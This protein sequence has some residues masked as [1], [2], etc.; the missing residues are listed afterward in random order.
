MIGAVR[1]GGRH[2]SSCPTTTSSSPPGSAQSY[3][4]HDEYAQWAPGMKTHRRRAGP[5]AGGS[6]A[7][8]RWRRPRPTDDERRRWLTFALVGGG[9]TG[10][11]LAGQIRE[12]ATKTLRDEFRKIRPGGRPGAALRR[13]HSAAGRVRAE[14]RRQG[15]EALEELGVELHDGL[16]GHRR[17][18][19]WSRG[20]RQRRCPRPGTRPAPCC[21]P[22]ESRRRRSPACVAAATGA[23]Q[24]R[25]GRIVVQPDLTVAGSPGDLR[26]RRRDEPRRP[27]RARRGGDAVG[28][29]RRPSD[30]AP[31]CRQGSPEAV[32]LHRP[33]Q[34]GVHL[35]WPGD[36][37]GRSDQAVRPAGLAE[38]AV[39]PHR[40][41]DRLPQ[42]VHRGPDVVRGFQPRHA[43]RTRVH[44]GGD[45][46]R[47][48]VYARSG[49]SA[50][51]VL[52]RTP[53]EAS[54][55]GAH[56]TGGAGPQSET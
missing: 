13:R 50:P 22:P 39:H 51:V 34:R 7:R 42:P 20:Q 43:A 10:V 32:P 3:F 6:S 40:V 48:D 8:S 1:P 54:P 4:G 9:P 35:P 2:A 18:R 11:E 15:G 37:L 25:A 28:R 47:R 19:R 23:E 49:A 12:L 31:G 26:R 44:D 17:R 5:S 36:H 52:P 38:L 21:G 56:P 46:Q 41:P 29:L 45:P 14:A 27:A 16:P 24:D 30:P 33:G 55:A 53:A